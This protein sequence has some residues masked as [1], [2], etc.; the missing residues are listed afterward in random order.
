MSVDAAA[1]GGRLDLR[2]APGRPAWAAVWALGLTVA[3]L[4]TSEMLPASLLTPMAAGLD[5]SEG[6]IG[7]SV[8]AT[9]LLAIATSL[10]IGPATRR[11]DRR[12]VL[13]VVAA[14]Q[15]LSNLVVALAPT[16]GI[17]LAGRVLL[18]LTVGGV[19]GLSASLAL[20]LVPS[21]GVPR[22]MSIIFGGASVAMIAATPIGAFLGGIIG[23][24]GVFIA[25]AGLS[26]AAVLALALALPRLPSRAAAA[27]SGLGHALR[28][29][30]LAAGMLGVML[31]F[32]GLQVF[33]TYLRPFLEA[34]GGFGTN[35]VALA[36]LVFG[37]AGFLG[38]MA[39]PAFL[40]RSVRG[41]LTGSA[42]GQAV[43]LALLFTFGS[44]SQPATLVLIACWGFAS[45]TVGVGW[46]TWLAR[47]YPDHAEAGGGILVAAIQ[48]A[49]MLGATIGGGLIDTVGSIGPLL[50]AVTLL[51]LGAVH[52]CFALRHRA[53]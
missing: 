52:T 8:T 22:A 32:G 24:R 15:V 10:F 48:A 39:A 35:G 30:G 13:L 25:A 51:A 47:T 33:S 21:E 26:A 45:G 1:H 42:I 3:T 18:G 41:A 36:L 6:L 23:W 46:S 27:Q 38:T 40:R 53:R 7:Q 17:M 12:T 20:R 14:A 50:A 28:L 2:E 9:A 16:A 19:W 37:A 5:A 4:N 49:M 43:F 34:I 11:F 31:L 29:P 44:G